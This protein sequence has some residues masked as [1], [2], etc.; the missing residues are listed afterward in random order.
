MCVISLGRPY[1][2]IRKRRCQCSLQF[3]QKRESKLTGVIYDPMVPVN[4]KVWQK[5]DK[6]RSS[7]DLFSQK[8][9]SVKCCR[10][11]CIWNGFSL[12]YVVRYIS[13]LWMFH[14]ATPVYLSK[15]VSTWVW[16]ILCKV[17][18][19]VNASFVLGYP[20]V[21]CVCLLLRRIMTCLKVG[22]SSAVQQLCFHTA[23]WT[24]RSSVDR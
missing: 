9:R 8:R 7:I 21:R 14:A 6:G 19:H 17:V 16:I 15:H 2:K 4:E 13:S 5:A 22:I 1:D 23:V 3:K 10:A 18:R 20:T 24:E 11:S 12:T